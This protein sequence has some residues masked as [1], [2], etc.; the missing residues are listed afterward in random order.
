MAYTAPAAKAAVERASAAK[1]TVTTPN[2]TVVILIGFSFTTMS[3]NALP[4][5]D[6]KTAAQNLQALW[7]EGFISSSSYGFAR[8]WEV[9]D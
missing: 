6:G 7:P 5:P 8:L 1:R 3:T 2:I 9:D 4:T